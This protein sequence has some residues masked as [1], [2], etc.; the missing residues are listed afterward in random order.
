MN[1][2][3]SKSFPSL[4]FREPIAINNLSK[5]R[6]VE[7][8]ILQLGNISTMQI[9]NQQSRKG[10]KVLHVWD[11]RAGPGTVTYRGKSSMTVGAGIN[12]Q[13]TKLI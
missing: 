12:G 4:M 5:L 9:L 7:G 2:T 13:K 3:F 11:A 8:D 10:T 1:Y 6:I